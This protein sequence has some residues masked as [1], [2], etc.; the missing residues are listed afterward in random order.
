MANEFEPE[1][2][3]DSDRLPYAFRSAGVGAQAGAENRGGS[4]YELAPGGRVSPLH[5][6]HAN[7]E[8]IIVLSG[9]AT[10]HTEHETRRL[11]GAGVGRSS[12]RRHKPDLARFACARPRLRQT[13]TGRRSSPRDSGIA[14]RATERL[15]LVDRW[16]D[17]LGDPRGGVW[18]R[19]LHTARAGHGRSRYSPVDEK[20]L[21]R[22]R[23]A[24]E[25]NHVGTQ[26]LASPNQT[27]ASMAKV[28]PSGS[29]NQA[30]RPPPARAVIPLA[31]C[32]NWA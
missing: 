20:A 11:L 1:W 24:L 9:Q 25:G 21:E 13:V 29:W 15:E 16:G 10:V 8:M 19:S 30:M 17:K 22:F 3:L 23:P 32:A 14:P 28:L 27:S 7:E 31:S 12:K 26:Q 2:E 5:V 6:H 18:A 4:L